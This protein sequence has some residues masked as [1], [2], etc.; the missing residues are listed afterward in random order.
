MVL[1]LG[2]LAF[3]YVVTYRI[4]WKKGDNPIASY[5]FPLTCIGTLGIVFGMYICACIV[6][7]ST[8]ETNWVPTDQFKSKGTPRIIW[9]QKKQTVGDQGFQS[10]AIYAPVSTKDGFL[11]TSF[12]RGE[13]HRAHF[14]K[15]T[16][17]ASIL[18][19]GGE[20]F[21]ADRGFA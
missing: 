2:V 1:Q 16:L 11:A 8:K 15:L 13:R 9:V 14:H 7:E 5:A 3:D 19:V 4:K 18:S 6:E 21:L 17:I 20:C 12:K 10:F